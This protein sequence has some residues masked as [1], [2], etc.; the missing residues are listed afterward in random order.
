MTTPSIKFVEILHAQNF[1]YR[2]WHI[3]KASKKVGTI[4]SFAG[5]RV[6]FAGLYLGRE[7]RYSV[8][9]GYMRQAKRHPSLKAAQ[10]SVIE[11]LS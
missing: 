3:I 1:E 2:C 7:I 8:T 11:T 10:A 9:Y 6:M 5:P 4:E